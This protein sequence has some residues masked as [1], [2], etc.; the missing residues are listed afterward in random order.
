MKTKAAKPQGTVVS[1]GLRKLGLR[2][3]ISQENQKLL[4]RFLYVCLFIGIL[5]LISAALV[6]LLEYRGK[7]ANTIESFWDGIWWAIVTAATVG[8]GDK[9]PVTQ[10]GR[11]VGML[12][13]IIGFASLSVFTGMIA[14]LFVEDRL[15]GARG[16]KQLHLSNHIVICGWN[17]TGH[18][19]LSALIE[20]AGMIPRSAF[21]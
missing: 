20:K 8:Y 6:W 17:N 4:L 19:F 1:R 7:G 9:Y 18:F 15:K 11:L 2:Y 16:L 13:I 10:L 21:C 3:N 14:S 12:L 5:L